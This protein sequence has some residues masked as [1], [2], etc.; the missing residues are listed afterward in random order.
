MIDFLRFLVLFEIFLLP[1][2]FATPDFGFEESKI[3]FFIFFNSLI[4]F[5]WWYLLINKKIKFEFSKIKK[6]GL[7]FIG[8]LVGTRLE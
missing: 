5:L 3:V 8:I 4:G 6:I 1:L 7:I 2:I